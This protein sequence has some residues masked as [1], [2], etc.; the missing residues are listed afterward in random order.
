VTRSVQSFDQL[1]RTSRGHMKGPETR[2][3]A[4]FYLEHHFD[5]IPASRPTTAS[6]RT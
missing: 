1:D 3:D 4:G 6:T 2:G 5:S